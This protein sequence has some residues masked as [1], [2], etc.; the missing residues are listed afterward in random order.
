MYGSGRFVPIRSTRACLVDNRDTSRVDP[1]THACHVDAAESD[2][3]A[4]SMPTPHYYMHHVNARTHRERARAR[5]RERERPGFGG[6]W[7]QRFWRFS[8]FS[9]LPS[10]PC[11]ASSAAALRQSHPPTHTH[12]RTHA[13]ARAR[14]HTHTH[15]HTHKH[16][17][18]HANT[19]HQHPR[20]T[21][22]GG[23]SAAWQ[24]PTHAYVLSLCDLLP[25][26]RPTQSFQY[27]PS[28]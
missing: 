3:A 1:S 27:M 14:A 5:A 6:W 24:L 7:P 12:A 20:D 8:S 15:I 17:P 9:A 18:T 25:G 19:H 23:C 2:A 16:T 10:V 22:H 21:R 11:L 28:L 26:K 13:R 4:N